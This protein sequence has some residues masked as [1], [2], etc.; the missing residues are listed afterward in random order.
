MAQL[1][2]NRKALEEIRRTLRREATFA[3]QL[4]WQQIRNKQ[5]GYKFRRQ[6]SIGSFVVDFYC[7][8]KR[9]VLE[10]DGNIHDE[11]EIQ[12]ND[13][14]RDSVLAEMYIRVLRIKNDDI[15]DR[16][17]DALLTIRKHLDSA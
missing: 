16:M 14:E 3:E 4:L 5:L 9:L 10:I 12:I 7:P 13:Q 17:P 1:I 8:E 15:Y 6:H 11:S 2:H